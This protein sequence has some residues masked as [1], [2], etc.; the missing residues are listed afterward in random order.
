MTGT[1]ACEKGHVWMVGNILANQML[2]YNVT[3]TDF[4]ADSPVYY[5]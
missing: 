4:Q 3:T 2:V 5:S 1:T